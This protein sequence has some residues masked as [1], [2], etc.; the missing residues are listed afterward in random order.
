MDNLQT[1]Q[2]A[3]ALLVEL[4]RY[5]G[6][7]ADLSILREGMIAI[8]G[9]GYQEGISA[10]SAPVF[11]SEEQVVGTLSIIGP[12]SRMTEDTLRLCGKQCAQAAPQLSSMIRWR[13]VLCR[14][15]WDMG[16]GG[17]FHGSF[18]NGGDRF[19]RP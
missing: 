14:L 4:S 12:A 11:I 13:R 2:S 5:S 3:Q 10:V 18:H 15:K 1:H 19:R 8:V 6:E 7:T 16:E 17:C 9:E